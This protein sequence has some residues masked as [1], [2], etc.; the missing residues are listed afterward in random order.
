VTGTR[1]GDELA[2]AWIAARMNVPERISSFGR[3]LYLSISKS[4][5]GPIERIGNAK[6]HAPCDHVPVHYVDHCAFHRFRDLMMKFI[7]NSSWS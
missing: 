3:S 1:N 6:L 4:A 7:M 5:T 2:T